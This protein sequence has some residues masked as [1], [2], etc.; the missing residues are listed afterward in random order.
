MCSKYDLAKSPA[1]SGIGRVPRSRVEAEKGAGRWAGRPRFHHSVG[2]PS[3]A[4]AC[5]GF[6]C[7]TLI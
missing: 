4:S 1:F 6:A 5:G 2:L 3:E 7:R